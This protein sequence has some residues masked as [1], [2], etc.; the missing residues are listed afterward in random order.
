MRGE[1]GGWR[2]E[3]EEGGGREDGGEKKR[4]G[5]RAR[6]IEREKERER[7]RERER[8]SMHVHRRQ[9]QEGAKTQQQSLLYHSCS[10]TPIKSEGVG[11]GGGSYRSE[12]V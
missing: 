7:E 3:K 8:E 9:L 2:R 12:T 10:L 5:A 4:D 1:G 6:P 11:W